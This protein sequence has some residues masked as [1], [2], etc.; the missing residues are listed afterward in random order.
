MTEN[1]RSTEFSFWLL[2]TAPLAGK[3]H[4]II[5]K[6]AA[7]FDAVD[8]EPHVTLYSGP[9]D[10]GEAETVARELAAGFPP[11]A[12]TPLKIDCTRLYTKTLFVQC[13]ESPAAWTMFEFVKNHC[14]KPS[15]YRLDPHLSL[16]YKTMDP[17]AQAG[18]CRT[19]GASKEP[20]LFDRLRVIETEIP[21]TKPEQIARWRT[22]ME[23]NLKNPS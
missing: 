8:F 10:D 22:V 17:A 18:L 3:L 13:A 15:A 1:I 2:P 5:Q 9:S 23:V 7:R 19:L 6:L 16:L 14:A 12:L 21:L 20:Y 11:F 4:T